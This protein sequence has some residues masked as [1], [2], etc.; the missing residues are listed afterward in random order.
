MERLQKI[1]ARAGVASRRKA[2]RLIA[3]GHVRVNGQ[4]VTELGAKVNPAQDQ[5]EVNHRP[6]R[7]ETPVYFLFHKPVGVITSVTDPQGRRVVLDFFKDVRERIYPVGRLDCNTSGLLLLTNDG[8]LAHKLMHPS[9]QVQKSYVATVRGLPAEDKL[10]QLRKGV[11][12]KDGLTAP[13]NV[14]LIDHQPE[15]NRSVIRMTIYEG[16]KRQVRRM[17]RYIHHPVI[18]LHRDRYAFLTLEGVKSGSYRSLTADEVHKLHK[19]VSHNF[20]N[21][22]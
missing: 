9:F 8:Q 2:E 18:R 10:E 14:H 5:I 13:A 22:S 12:L 3:D 19:L 11:H 17:F 15:R 21:S 1:L 4:V 6:I 20:H 7:A 16:R